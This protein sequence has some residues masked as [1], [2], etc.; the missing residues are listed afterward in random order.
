MQDIAVTVIVLACMG[1]VA[2]ALMPLIARNWIRRIVLRQPP[3]VADGCGACSSCG[4]SGSKSSTQDKNQ[5][6]KVM[7]R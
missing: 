4:Q 5:V 1:Y 7:R 6:V 2:W 3:K